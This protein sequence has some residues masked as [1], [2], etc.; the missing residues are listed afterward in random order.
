MTEALPLV[1]LLVD[2]GLAPS[3]SQGRRLIQ[4]GGVRLDGVTVDSP[5]AL[6]E[7]PHGSESVVLQVGRRRFL[8]IMGARERG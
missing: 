4:Q 2:R 8:R 3:K 6:L 1:D 5:E 7:P